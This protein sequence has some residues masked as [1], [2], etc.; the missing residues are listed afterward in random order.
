MHKLVKV[1]LF[2]SIIGMGVSA[3]IARETTDKD[4]GRAPLFEL[5]TPIMNSDG[6][7]IVAPEGVEIHFLLLKVPSHKFDDKSYMNQ[8]D[9]FMKDI[10]TRTGTRCVAIPDTHYPTATALPDYKNL[11]P[12]VYD[13]R[14]QSTPYSS[15]VQKRD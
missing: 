12:K 8:L 6:K 9:S 14:T 13:L 5:D 4:S 11:T 2:T 10:V 7:T 3:I 1:M 15:A